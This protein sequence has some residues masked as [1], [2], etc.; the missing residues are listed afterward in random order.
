MRSSQMST[1]LV[2]WLGT[3]VA[4]PYPGLELSNSATF[5]CSSELMSQQ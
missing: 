5:T 4:V 2:S 3:S 1:K